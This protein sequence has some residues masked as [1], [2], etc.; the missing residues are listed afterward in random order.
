MSTKEFHFME[1][2]LDVEVEWG[3]VRVWIEVKTFWEDTTDW[4]EQLGLAIQDLARH[5]KTP[6]DLLEFLAKAPGVTAM[7]IRLKSSVPGVKPGF[8][9]YTVPF[10]DVHG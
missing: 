7:G 4:M 1:S 9:V 10:E 6:K 3:E 2:T 5:A 8:M